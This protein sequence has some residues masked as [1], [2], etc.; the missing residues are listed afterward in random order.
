[1]FAF[2]GFR[3]EEFDRSRMIEVDGVAFV[4][5]DVD[6]QFDVRVFAYDHIFE[7]RGATGGIDP[8]V[9]AVAVGTTVV[10]TVSG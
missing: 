7:D 1:M 4:G 5:I 8:Q 6:F 10:S 3:D 9:Q 2:T